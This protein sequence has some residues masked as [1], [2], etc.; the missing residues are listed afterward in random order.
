VGGSPYGA[1]DT[2]ALDLQLGQTYYWQVNEV[3]EVEV[4]ATWEGDIVAFS[5][6]EFLVVDDF[7]S[8]SNDPATFGRV[9]QTW[10]DGAGYTIPVEVAGNG[11]GSYIGHDPQF[12]DIME[13]VIVHGG[14]QSAPIYYGNDG[15]TVSEVDRT[16]DEPQDW[17]RAGI[18]TLAIAFH[19][20]SGNTGQL[21]VKINN[22]RVGYDL[23][24]ADIAIAA[25]QAWN[26]DLSTVPANL[27]NVTKLTIGVDG[28]G[29]GIFYV[30]DIRLYAKAGE[31]I[32]PAAPDTAKRIFIDGYLETSNTVDAD[33]DLSGTSQHNAYIGAITDNSSGSLYKL[34]KGLIDEVRVYSRALSAE[35][36]LWL[37]GRTTPVHKPL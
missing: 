33:Y 18:K 35:E 26:I 2:S 16:F 23:D 34:F 10:I 13:K 15:K 28:G 9:F 17:T 27:Q 31:S 1:Y 29:A 22:T 8:Y 14:A 3:N 37:A 30:D 24:A 20:A 6:R 11:T 21:Y 19:G 36:I 12:G 7:E 4:P 25:W 5:T 32:T